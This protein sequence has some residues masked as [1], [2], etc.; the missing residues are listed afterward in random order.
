MAAHE[1]TLVVEQ[2][3]R[4]DEA[5]DGVGDTLGVWNAAYLHEG[6]L[7]LASVSN[8]G[9]IGA[10]EDIGGLGENHDSSLAAFRL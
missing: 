5:V 2:R 10:L 7:F 9:S 1:G 8:K 6:G 3:H 4:D